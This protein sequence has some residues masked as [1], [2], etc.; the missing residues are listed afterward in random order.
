MAT[1]M[2]D[3]G[4]LFPDATQQTTAA[5]GT[6]ALIGYQVFTS[7]GTYTKGTN[8]PSFVIVEVQGGGGNG[9]PGTTIASSGGGGGGYSR[10]TILSS[11]LSASETVTVGGATGT[12]SFG[13]HCSATGGSSGNFGSVPGNGG[14]GSNG[15]LNIKGDGG[16]CASQ[17]NPV[18]GGNGGSSMLGAGADTQLLANTL[19]KNGGN[20]GGGGG[21]T[22]RSTSGTTNGG[23][24]A[25]GVVIVWEFK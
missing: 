8:N 16:Y 18:A 12:S 23:A 25:P 10:K 15:D 13:S 6:G 5:T 3:L 17:T 4:I 20:Y 11:I 19:G 2:N 22:Y 1:I 9:G 14:L 24:G 21:G 7:S